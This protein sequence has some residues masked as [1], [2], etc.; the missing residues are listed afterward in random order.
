M[1]G[2]NGARSRSALKGYRMVK[3]QGWITAEK[4]RKAIKKEE[5]NKAKLRELER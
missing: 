1:P 5:E 2:D 3:Y 4:V